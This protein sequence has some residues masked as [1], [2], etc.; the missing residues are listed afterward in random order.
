LLLGETLYHFSHDS[1][2]SVTIS[3]A[4]LK[5]PAWPKRIDVQVFK[6]GLLSAALRPDEDIIQTVQ[7][8]TV[9]EPHNPLTASPLA[10]TVNSTSFG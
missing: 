3:R 7:S 9:S 10:Y 5:S 2:A 6:N 4:I 1:R 8:A